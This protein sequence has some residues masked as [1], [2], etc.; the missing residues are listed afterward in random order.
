MVK[1]ESGT[2]AILP[3]LRIFYDTFSEEIEK[4]QKG[5]ARVAENQ[6]LLDHLLN[7]LERGVSKGKQIYFIYLEGKKNKKHLEKLIY[8]HLT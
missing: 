4:H 7:F 8:T 3:S 2:S 5:K 6:H 1:K